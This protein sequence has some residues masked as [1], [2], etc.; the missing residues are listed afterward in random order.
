MGA[1]T[2]PRGLVVDP[3]S[4]FVY[5]ANLGSA[6]VSGYTK[7]PNTGVLT[8]MTNSPFAAGTSPIGVTTDPLGKFAFVSNSGSNNL[9]VYSID[10]TT[11][12]LTQLGAP[13]AAAGGAGRAV[14][15]QIPQPKYR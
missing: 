13:Y 4:R 14:V 15:V 5:V 8:P 2:T 3:T 1:G 10:K 12:A 9:S 7:N 6:N 11:G